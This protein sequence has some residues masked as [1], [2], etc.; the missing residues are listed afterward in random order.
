MEAKGSE[1]RVNKAGIGAAPGNIWKVSARKAELA[2]VAQN[3]IKSRIEFMFQPQNKER[4]ARLQSLSPVAAVQAWLDGDFGVGDEP[5]LIGAIRKDARVSLS[6]D[7]IT[8]IIS[9]AMD[10]GSGAPACLERMAGSK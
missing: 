8:D 5:A 1:G 4:F 10:D 2:H 7:A 9:E 3:R 6:D